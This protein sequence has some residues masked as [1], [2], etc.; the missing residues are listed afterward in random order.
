LVIVGQ[1][2]NVGFQGTSFIEKLVD[3][4]T[5]HGHVNNL[6]HLD[7]VPEDT[8]IQLYSACDVLL[9]PSLHESFGFPVVEAMACGKPVVAAKTGIV[10][11]IGLDGRSGSVIPV[12]DAEALAREAVKYL[13]L[14]AEE[15]A[16]IAAVN[17]G[18]IRSRF[19]AG[20]WVAEM[21]RVYEVALSA[22]RA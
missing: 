14:S 17:S 15:K 12:G 4:A 2:T 22:A 8:L 21:E 5:S 16:S 20:T 6:V 13:L 1:D 3:Q 19:S 11:E 10:S 9:F 7:S 18:I